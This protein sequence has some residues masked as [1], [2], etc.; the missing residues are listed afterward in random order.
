M[1]REQTLVIRRVLRATCAE[2]FAAWTD[3][4]SLQVW[5]CPG[6][7]VAPSLVEMDLRVGGAFRIDMQSAQGVSVHTGVYREITPPSRLV[8]TWRSSA[9]H[10]RET[11]VTVEIQPQAGGAELV[12]T[13]RAL[14]DE[15]SAEGHQGG[16]TA[17]LARLAEWLEQQ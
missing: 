11:L 6:A 10:D 8:F 16:W 5:M 9:A 3:P 12:L 7:G 14:P 13:H 17:I 4:A 1:T 2:I 15:Q